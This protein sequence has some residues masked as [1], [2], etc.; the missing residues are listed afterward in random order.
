VYATLPQSPA[1]VEETLG[2]VLDAPLVVL[3]QAVEESQ[4]I[5]GPPQPAPPMWTPP[6][7]PID[8]QLLECHRTSVA[9]S[10][11]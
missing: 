5:Q 4:G 7:P 9:D 6:V 1:N 3:V 8:Q 11:H 10:H 2:H